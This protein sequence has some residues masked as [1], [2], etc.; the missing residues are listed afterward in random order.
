MREQDMRMR[1]FAFLKAR[2]RNM[3]MPATVGLG[4]AVG[5][6]CTEQKSTPA[7]MA[8]F[9][10]D[11]A[12]AGQDV[13]ALRDVRGGESAQA[14]EVAQAADLS[15]PWSDGPSG[16]DMLADLGRDLMSP[17][18]GPSM[19]DVAGV[20]DLAANDA[21]LADAAGRP[22]SVGDLGGMKYIA[23]FLDAGP[24]DSGSEPG[25][26]RYVAPFLDAGAA[27]VPSTT[28]YIAQLPDA[29]PDSTPV[30]RY[31]AQMPDPARDNRIG[32]LYL[33]QLPSGV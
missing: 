20:G 31:L 19:S 8:P 21:A 29:G 16:R 17:S 33:A 26:M 32:V 24:M 13:S 25:G 28:K 10:S 23:P 5:A 4:L 3:I 14:P 15:L 9:Y 22:D 7:Y 6:A 1:V 12:T 27:D 2:M 11:A 18:E 30:L